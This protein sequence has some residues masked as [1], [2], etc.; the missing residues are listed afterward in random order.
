MT[1][2]RRLTA[3]EAHAWGLVA[4]VVEADK[5]AEHVAEVARTYA[6]LPTRA[7]G[8]TKRLFDN[9]YDAS[10]EQQLELE[11]ELQAGGD[12]QAGRLRRRRRRLPR[13]REPRFSG[14]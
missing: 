9:A 3:A 7:I 5:L 11:A 12:R 8:M 4:E 14:R 6:A 13:R 1:S 10:L 2:N